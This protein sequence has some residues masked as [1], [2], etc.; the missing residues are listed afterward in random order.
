MSLRLLFTQALNSHNKIWRDFY[1][2][3]EL[4]HHIFS[5]AEYISFINQV[6][7][8]IEFKIIGE[9]TKVSQASS[10]HV[11]FTL[12]DKKEDVVLDCIV[13]KGNYLINS[14]NLESG[15]EI[16]VSGTPTIYSYSGRFSY[17]VKTIERVGE[18]ALKQAYL[19][20][21]RNLEQEG[22]FMEKRKRPLPPIV[23]KIGVI[24]SKQGAVIHDFMNNVGVHGF[25]I[26]FIDSR[27]EGQEAVF[28]L[29]SS[30][31]T[32]KKK[33]VEVLVIMRGGGSL[34]SLSPFDNEVIVRAIAQFPVPVIAAI[35]HHE[36]K[37][38]TAMAAD[39]EVSTPTAAAHLLHTHAL[40]PIEQLNQL[41]QSI[42]VRYRN[43]FIEYDYLLSAETIKVNYIT[44]LLH[45]LDEQ[46]GY[47]QETYKQLLNLYS[48]GLKE[49]LQKL[50]HTEQTLLLHHPLR[51]LKKGYSIL[52]YQGNIVRS[53]EQL[54]IN[55]KL[56]VVVNDGSLVSHID[57]IKRGEIH[58]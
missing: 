39:F 42:L 30:I 29:L 19:A 43:L 21:K 40:R 58:E 7:K 56:D 57:S 27:V 2:N 9:V 24:T 5:I 34:Q 44:P 37:T 6:L 16:I 33:D 32:L 50:E 28:D 8:P 15:M 35:G 31:N 23:H 47:V 45:T 3:N 26:K 25:D 1:M 55:M 36:D 22:L 46:I 4:Q 14:V 11:Y 52:K 17:I 41:F 38:L 18:G 20:L 12:K 54:T 51:L 53:V 48:R 49:Q 13:W 10:G